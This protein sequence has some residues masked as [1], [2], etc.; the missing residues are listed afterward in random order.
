MINV[1]RHRTWKE[2]FKF[3]VVGLATVYEGL[4]IVVSLGFLNTEARSNLLFSDWID[5]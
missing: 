2:Q 1:A 5:R 4:V 3:F